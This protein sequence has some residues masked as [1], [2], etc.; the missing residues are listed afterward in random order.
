MAQQKNTYLF[1]DVET[2]GLNKCF[3]QVLQFAAIRTDMKLNELERHEINIRLNPDVIPSPEAIIV[4]RISI[5][6]SQSGEKEIDA[7]SKI[8]QLLNT[9]GTI[10]VGY[11]TLNFDDEFLRFSFYRNCLPPYT[12]QY[13]NQCSRMDI[14]PITVMFY[15]YKP[16]ALEWPKLN[17]KTSLKLE[18]LSTANKLATGQAHNAMVDVEATLNLA[19]KL[20]QHKEMWDY[21]CGYFN[22]ETDLQ[23]MTQLSISFESQSKRFKEALLIN[24]KFGSDVNYMAPVIHLGDHKHYKN[25]SL[26]MRLDTEEL[27]RCT[28]E[29]IPETTFVI[30]K[31]LAENHLL[32]PMQQRF[33]KKLNPD[34]LKLATAN[35]IWLQE[36]PKLLE[37]ICDYHQHY[38]YPKVPH[39]DID[40]AL[41]EIGFP[42]PREELLFRQFHNAS[43]TD[44]CKIAEQF[45]NAT[46][47][48]QAIRI[49]GRH[50]PEYLSENHLAVFKDYLDSVYSASDKS[51]SQDYK[52]EFRLTP[53]A[54][55]ENIKAL[56]RPEKTL[57]NEQTKLLNELI[58]YIQTLTETIL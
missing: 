18:H 25:Q 47:R 28:E 46:R 34:R 23:R 16:E 24:G 13:A 41:Y 53:Q 30:R 10:S 33:L 32:L 49:M 50:Y 40:A 44:K 15:L 48:E 39:L 21:L 38:K 20:I 3:D 56:L 43:S 37:R 54:A 26:W 58:E 36:N 52:G 7:I 14:Y 22:K 57:G 45:P 8:H 35:K 27:Q 17:G 51:K 6:Q 4:H 1:Y 29:N 42:T 19:K 55:I 9:P 5:T 11:N 2:T 12:H 31:K